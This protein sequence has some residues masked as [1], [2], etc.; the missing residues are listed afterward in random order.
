[1]ENLSFSQS[2]RVEIQGDRVLRF[3]AL[4][5]Q[6]A[7]YKTIGFDNPTITIKDYR[8]IGLATMAQLLETG[9]LQ[10]FAPRFNT[11]AYVEISVQD[12]DILVELHETDETTPL[13][14]LWIAIGIEEYIPVYDYVFEHIAPLVGHLT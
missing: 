4:D 10:E 2:A 11:P 1:M 8:P 13:H 9:N 6:K 3:V 14:T 7:E 5:K 12:T